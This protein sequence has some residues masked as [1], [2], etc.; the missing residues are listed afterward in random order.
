MSTQY[1]FEADIEAALLELQIDRA[2]L[3]VQTQIMDQSLAVMLWQLCYSKLRFIVLVPGFTPSFGGPGFP[4]N[5]GYNSDQGS[6]ET[7]S[8]FYDNNHD[9]EEASPSRGGQQGRILL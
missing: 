4:S 2:K 9:D 1:L 7:P 5:I 3:Q 8:G 6:D